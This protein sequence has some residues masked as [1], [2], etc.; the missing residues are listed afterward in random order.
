[1]HC[2]PLK[3]NVFWKFDELWMKKSLGNV[4]L[5]SVMVRQM[6]GQTIG[7]G[8]SIEPCVAAKMIKRNMGP[9]AIVHKHRKPPNLYTGYPLVLHTTGPISQ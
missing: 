4:A 5:R 6:D 1:M 7:R 9:T 2:S 3:L 8:L